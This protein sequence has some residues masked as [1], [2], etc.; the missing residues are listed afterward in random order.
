MGNGVAFT[1]A[2][3]TAVPLLARIRYQYS[4]VLVEPG[5]RHGRGVG[6]HV[7]LLSP[8]VKPAFRIIFWVTVIASI[9]LA[10][11]V[12]EAPLVLP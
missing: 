2:L 4:G 8:V 1:H 9:A 12:Y 7:G 6:C 11:F 3:D 5:L 10:W